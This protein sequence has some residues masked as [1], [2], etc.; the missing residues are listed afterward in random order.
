MEGMF[1]KYGFTHFIT[2]SN[3]KL[4]IYL[5]SKPEEYN[6]IYNDDNFCIYEKNK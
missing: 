5:D 2:T 6:K 3:A 1:K 4:R